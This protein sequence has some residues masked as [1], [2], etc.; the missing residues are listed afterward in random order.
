MKGLLGEEEQGR[1]VIQEPP[2]KAGED[3]EPAKHQGRKESGE[4][5]NDY[6]V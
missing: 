5:K 2:A 1:R 3:A 4:N 6:D